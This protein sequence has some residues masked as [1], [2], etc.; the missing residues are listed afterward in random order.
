MSKASN[1]LKT[2]VLAAH[3]GKIDTLFVA[4]GIQ[5][6][7][8]IDVMQN[9]VETEPIKSGKSVEIL[10]FAV[11]QTLLNKGTVYALPQEEMPDST[12]LQLFFVINEP[13]P[14]HILHFCHASR[15]PG[16]SR[17]RIAG[18]VF[19]ISRSVCFLKHKLQGESVAFAPAAVFSLSRQGPWTILLQGS[20]EPHA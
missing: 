12:S 19:Q 3:E 11:V 20:G 6:W 10:D 2:V 13:P 4:R 9:Q 1:D 8:H 16:L 15:F 5:Q 18:W 7:G 17:K 14:F